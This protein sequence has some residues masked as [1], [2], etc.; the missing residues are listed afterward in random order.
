MRKRLLAFLD[1]E[2]KLQNAVTDK[3][4]KQLMSIQKDMAKALDQDDD[5]TAVKLLYELDY[6]D[7]VKKAS[8]EV[9]FMLVNALMLGS[10]GVVPVSKSMFL[11]EKN[12]PQEIDTIHALYDKITGTVSLDYVQRNAAI[13]IAN[14][15]E[16]KKDR[17]LIQKKLDQGFVDELNAAVLG[18]T[19]LINDIAGNLTTSRLVSYG[20]LAEANMRGVAYYQ[21]QAILDNRTSE[22]CQRLHGRTFKVEESFQFTEKVL[23]I[24]EPEQLKMMAPFVKSTK[25]SLH[26][27]ENLSNEEL[28]SRGIMVPPFHP[29]CRTL[30]VRVGEAEIEDAEYTPTTI[31]EYNDSLSI[32]SFEGKEVVF[33][34]WAKKV[35]PKLKDVAPVEFYQSSEGFILNNALRRVN[36]EAV[37][38][39]AKKYLADHKEVLSALDKATT[40]YKFSSDTVV[41]R[42][43]R[44]SRYLFGENSPEEVIGA[45]FKELGFTS[46]TANIEMA[47]RWASRFD[48]AD[49]LPAMIHIKIKKGQSALIPHAQTGKHGSEMEF[50]LPRGLRF[51][52]TGVKRLEKRYDVFMEIVDG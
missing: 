52:I 3:L 32:P 13:T 15:L 12:L 10:S 43:V 39:Q 40:S 22:V 14:I 45:T 35:S 1:I 18:G 44:T 21:L 2:A 47:T 16:S 20:F 46:T 50:L 23:G 41:M 11:H 4:R 5:A 33:S 38:D 26:A 36:V 28:Q 34:D 31:T 51:K 8:S 27:L 29:N 48:D 24:T 25:A 6:K 30:C 17:Q 49:E 42:G 9:D 37:A 19:K 7:A